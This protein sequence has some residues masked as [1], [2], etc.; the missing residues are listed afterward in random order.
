VSLLIT[1]DSRTLH[2]HA[3]LWRGDKVLSEVRTSAG[4]RETALTGSNE[5]LARGVTGC[6]VGV[7]LK[8]GISPE[9]VDVVVAS[10]MIT[11]S[12]G[13]KEVPHLVAPVGI[14]D[15]AAG[16]VS[17]S[18]PGVWHKPIWFVPG[19]KNKE[20]KVNGDDLPLMDMMRG[21]E[22][23]TVA[24]QQRLGTRN[25][26][27]FILPGSHTKFVRLSKNGRIMQIVSTLAGEMMDAL[28]RNTI[29]VASVEAG[30][31]VNPEWLLKGYRVSVE[32]GLN[33]AAYCVRLA[34]FWSESSNADRASYLLG[35]L[36]GSDIITLKACGAG[37]DTIFIAGREDLREAFVTLLG[38]DGSFKD[39]H[40][41]DPALLKDLAG[42]GALLLARRRGLVSEE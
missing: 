28:S 25:A 27:W 32:Q 15:L 41:V 13:L 2:S 22:V 17:E 34:Q 38:T 8:A 5:A 10:G 3:T 16:M 23:E 11:S 40:P 35:A 9:A 42:W 7:C 31:S 19:V 30:G 12:L 39:V 14:D 36:L 29:L 24:L 33:R 1:L 37:K 6:M 21:E 18:F 4:V 26:C 20:G